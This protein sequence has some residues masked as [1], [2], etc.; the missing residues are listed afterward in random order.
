MPLYPLICRFSQV[1]TGEHFTAR[2][3]GDARVLIE[4]VDGEWVCSGV[5]PGGLSDVGATPGEA[6]AAFRQFLGQILQDH[7]EESATMAD[8]SSA[9]VAFLGNLNRVNDSR[10]TEAVQVQGR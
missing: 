4:Q 9:A 6:Y 3:R 10:W 8:F 7:A 5:L 2:V 1:V